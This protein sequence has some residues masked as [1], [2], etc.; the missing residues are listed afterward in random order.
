MRVAQSALV[1]TPLSGP[2]M[3]LSLPTFIAM[4]E[5]ERN[6][7]GD[8]LRAYYHTIHGA[9]E[10]R[11]SYERMVHGELSVVSLS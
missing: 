6:A 9:N 8:E 1:E 7:Y 4:S 5:E 10:T 11:R 2:T 3:A